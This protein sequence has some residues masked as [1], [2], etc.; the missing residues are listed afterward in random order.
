MSNPKAAPEHA[1]PKLVSV[2]EPRPLY[3]LDYAR[4]MERDYIFSPM[5]E[6]VAPKKSKSRPHRSSKV[7]TPTQVRHECN[8]HNSKGTTRTNAK[9]GNP[10]EQ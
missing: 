9:P 4:R 7:A 5:P 10:F 2:N 3:V 6:G 1:P 8:I